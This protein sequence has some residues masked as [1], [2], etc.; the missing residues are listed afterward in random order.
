MLIEMLI[1]QQASRTTPHLHPT[2]EEPRSEAWVG[3]W[4]VLGTMIFLAAIMVTVLAVA[5]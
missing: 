5:A 4:V 1:I 2:E 3:F